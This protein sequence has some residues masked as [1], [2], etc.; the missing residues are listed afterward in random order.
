MKIPYWADSITI[1][2]RTEDAGGRVR[3]T[4]RHHNG[5]FWQQRAMRERIDGAQF[6]PARII[7][8]LPAPFPNVHIGDIIVRGIVKDDIDEY[9]AGR[10]SADLLKKYAGE[11]MIAAEVHRNMRGLPGT[12]HLYVGG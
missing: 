6:S 5:C 2:N 1:Y 8:R 12:D 9:A 7:C 4:R 3:W 11:S 10:R